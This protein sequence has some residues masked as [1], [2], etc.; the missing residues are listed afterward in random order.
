MKIENTIKL[1]ESGTIGKLITYQEDD[2]QISVFAFKG[3]KKKR[4]EH[5]N[6]S[7]WGIIYK[8]KCK[9]KTSNN[10]YYELEAGMYFC[11]NNNIELIG[12]E[13]IIIEYTNFKSL[14]TIGGPIEDS[15]RLAYI[16]GCTDTLIISPVKKGNPCLNV[17]YFPSKTIQTNHTHPSVRIGLVF[18]G[19]GQCVTHWG[20]TRL[21]EGDIFFIHKEGDD[22]KA[23]GEHAFKTNEENK[24]II[25]AFHPDS[26]FGP[27]NESHPMINRTIVG[28]I[29]ASLIPSI[30]T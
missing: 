6:A 18:S 2:Y 25:F 29:S 8:G 15:G 14:F 5:P 11:C 10:S 26:D 12:G 28:G 20:N 30:Q 22:D 27:D 21:K 4:L 19:E 17:L 1:W 16:N 13:G 3:N 24:M 9:I 7:F 23:I